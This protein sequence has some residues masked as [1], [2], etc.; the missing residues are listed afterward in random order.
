MRAKFAPLLLLAPLL[1]AV[2]PPPPP[3]LAED[4]ERRLAAGKVVVQTGLE[5]ARP[6]GVRNRTVAEID[7]PP[8]AVWAALLD[9]QARVPENR[10]LRRVE[11]YE[12][13]WEGTQLRR[14]ARW[15]LKIFGI[16]IVFHN[17]YVHDK[18]LNYLEWTL[19]TERENSLLYSWGSYQVLPSAINRGTSRLVYVSE[20]D[21]GRKLPKWLKTHF[22]VSGMTEL[23]E[24]VRTRALR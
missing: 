10:P 3:E 21:S 22:A 6:G 7:A 8:E 1:L 13:Q 18:D 20:T 5:P 16:E 15:E 12:D 9:F 2:S 19:D 14:K 17:A 11:I 24:G 23:I 4:E